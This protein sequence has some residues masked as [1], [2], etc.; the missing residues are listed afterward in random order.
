MTNAILFG[1]IG[2]LAETS[3]T[4]LTAYNQA[5]SEAG[6]PWKWTKREYQHMLKKAG[7]L[8]RIEKYA[9]ANN[10]AVNA[11]AIHQRKSAIFQQLLSLKLI[12]ARAGVKDTIKRAQSERLKL[13][14]VT[15]TSWENVDS[16]LSAVGIGIST[17]DVFTTSS[18]VEQPKPACDAYVTAL[19]HLKLEPE[20][21]IA[22]EDNPDGAKAAV[23]AG[24]RCVGLIGEMH[25]VA[26]FPEMFARQAKLDLSE[27]LKPQ[28][29]F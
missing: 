1:S 11:K 24:L 12:E 4:Q 23:R 26:D 3:A 13:G 18:T 10:T 5:F 6:L 9:K 19:E 8:E 7:G 25:D 21:A 29:V 15:T 27:V 14:L 22:I 28:A 2:A 20:Q 17:F 16:V